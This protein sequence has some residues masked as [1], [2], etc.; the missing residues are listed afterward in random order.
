[1]IETIEQFLNLLN[2]TTIEEYRRVCLEN[3]SE[4]VALDIIK[5]YPDFIVWIIRNK[6]VSLNILR[7]LV[8]YPDAAIR[9]EI[10]RKRK[11][12]QDLFEKLSQD[13]DETVRYTIACNPKTP[14]FILQKLLNDPI[15]FVS[16]IAIEQIKMRGN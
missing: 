13:D 16:N 2:S 1:M 11:L 4:S 5:H 10:A 9:T 15:P 14:Y 7:G 12:D 6:T 3:I 8:T